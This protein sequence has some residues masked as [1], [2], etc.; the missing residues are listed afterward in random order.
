MYLIKN[1][2]KIM[3]K[4][5]SRISKELKTIRDM[6]QLSKRDINYYIDDQNIALN[7]RVDDSENA[8]CELSEGLETSVGDIENAL[9]EIDS[10]LSDIENAL[11]ELTEE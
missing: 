10:A 4:I 7:E 11:C 5:E 2:E 1:G 9:I 6:I 8:T 3:K